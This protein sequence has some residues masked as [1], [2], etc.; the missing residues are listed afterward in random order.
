MKK[1]RLIKDPA[2]ARKA[3]GI[4]QAEFWIRFGVTQ[5]G[6]SRYES[7]RAIPKPIKLLMALL[8]SGTITD[9]DLLAAAKI[10]A[11]SKG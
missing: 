3:A 6:G 7:G 5:S 4:N 10:A 1:P 2:G 8:D 11:K 9:A